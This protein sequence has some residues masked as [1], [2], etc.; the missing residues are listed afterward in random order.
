MTSSDTAG[1]L[2]IYYAEIAPIVA[3]FED[4]YAKQIWLI[5]DWSLEGQQVLCKLLKEH[6]ELSHDRAILQLTFRDK[7]A[8]HLDQV[9]A[10]QP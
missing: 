10:Y 1:P 8:Q 6:P 2:S 4:L 7:F 5:S 3:H 9:R